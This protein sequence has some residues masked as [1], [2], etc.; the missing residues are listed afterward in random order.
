MNRHHILCLS[1]TIALGL[2]LLPSSTLAQQKSL[3]EQLVGTWTTVSADNVLP[4]G[5]KRQLF[6]ANPKGLIIFD[7]N[8]RY[9]FVQLDPD[10]PKFKVNNRLQGTPEEVK[11]AWDGAVAH[12][13]T[14]SVT[15]ADKTIGLRIEGSL[16]PNQSGTDGKRSIVSLTADELKW[17]NP[18]AGAGGRA[19]TV[20]KRAK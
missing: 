8:G 14:W 20:Y 9:A 12:F 10:R 11:A 2:A 4:D 6:G 5:T 15:E 1:V 19:E 13:G 17:I 3:K 7:A 18:A 16:Y